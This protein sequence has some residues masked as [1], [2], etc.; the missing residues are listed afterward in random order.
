MPYTLASASSMQRVFRDQPFD[1]PVGKPLEL[2]AAMNSW[3]SGQVVI[4]AGDKKLRNV[5]VD[6]SDLKSWEVSEHPVSKDEDGGVKH[7]LIEGPCIPGEAFQVSKVHYVEIKWPSSG[8]M[9][10][11]GWYPDPLEPLAAASRFEVEPGAV[12][13]IWLA[14]KVPPDT[15]PR[16]KS[17]YR[18]WYR[19]FRG[20]VT[21]HADVEG[22]GPRSVAIDIELRVFKFSLP[23]RRLLRIWTSAA[24]GWGEFYNWLSPKDLHESIQRAVLLLAGYGI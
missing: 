22:E 20:P 2:A 12:Q 19:L 11:P 13:P 23:R 1:G 15:R 17:L 6:V 10:R 14:L 5:R 9:S 3:A 4:I 16:N 8:K 21:V 18:R 24:A 7:A